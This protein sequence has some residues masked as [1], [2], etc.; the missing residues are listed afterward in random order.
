MVVSC[1]LEADHLTRRGRAES[2]MDCLVMQ[3]KQH[4][5]VHASVLSALVSMLP[6]M[7]DYSIHGSNPWHG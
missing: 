2:R 5:A 3:D 6:V 4:C 7:E 1:M